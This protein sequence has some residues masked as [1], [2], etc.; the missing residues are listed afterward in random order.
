MTTES[1]VNNL[2]VNNQIKVPLPISSG[3]LEYTDGTSWYSLATENFV[4]NSITKLK[5]CLAATTSNLLTTYTNGTAGVGAKLTNAVA[6]PFSVDGVAPLL[7]NGRILVKDQTVSAQN[8][9]Y[10][11]TDPGSATVPWVLTRATDY[12]TASQMLQGGLVE[13]IMGTVNKVSSWMQ[14]TTMS[15]IGI[16]NITFMELAKGGLDNLIGT[17]SQILVTVANNIATIS[18]ALNPVLPGMGSATLP[19]GTTAQRPVNLT[20]GMIRFNN[21]L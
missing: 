1:L 3:K 16:N 18:L 15:S 2:T 20:P 8:G 9:I 12:D 10:N 5:P 4:I 19:G 7:P 13:V 17:G 14:T 11:V 6:G 21:S